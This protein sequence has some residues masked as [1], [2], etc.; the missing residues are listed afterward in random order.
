[1][2]GFAGI[3]KS[4][5]AAVTSQEI[6]SMLSLIKYRG[7]DDSGML[8]DGPIGLGSVRLSI[9][10]LSSGRMPIKTE[11]E[12]LWIVYN[13][14]TY[15]YQKYK[16]DLL[17]KGH[18]FSTRSDTEVI[19][20]LYQEYGPSCFKLLNGMFGIC[21]WDKEKNQLVL[22]R[23]QLGQKPVYYA[24]TKKGFI[25]GSE[26][27]TILKQAS[28]LRVVSQ[29]GVMS[30]MTLGY[31]LGKLTMFE[32]IYQLEPGEYLTYDLQNES[33]KTEKFWNLEYN[34]DP[35]MTYEEAKS[36]VRQRMIQSVE[37]RMI[38][39]VPV[40]I[41]LSGG[42]DST[43]VGGIVSKILGLKLKSFALGYTA[44]SGGAAIRFNNDV[45]HADIAAK[46][47]GFD[48]HEH[49][50]TLQGQLP[51]ILEKIVW[52]YDEPCY[53]P[54]L[55]PL[56]LLSNL[57]A[58]DFKVSLTGDGGD[59]LFCGYEMYNLEKNFSGF[60][61]I[62]RAIR[63]P[64][65]GFVEGM[66]LFREGI[67]NQLYRLSTNNSLDRY[68]TWKEIFRRKKLPDYIKNFQQDDQQNFLQYMKKSSLYEEN[69]RDYTPHLAYNDIVFWISSHATRCFDRMSMAS[70]LEC[71]SSFLDHELVQFSQQIPYEYK[72]KNQ[73][74][75]SILK[76]AFSDLIPSEI[77]NRQKGSMLSPSSSW[78]RNHLNDLFNEL[79]SREAIERAGVLHYESTR[80]IFD[81]HVSKKRYAMI[82]VWTLASL[83]LWHE[84]HIQERRQPIATSFGT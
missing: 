8:L 71:R 84:I 63:A 52:H 26:I 66:G 23:D 13:G 4:Q 19:L 48:H 80:Q 45:L 44:E 79:F 39:D 11:D 10:G 72:L 17:K 21:I 75:K 31:C 55:V 2:C 42:I 5:N 1:M 54:T 67:Q 74:T 73:V 56:F 14:E 27:K 18:S 16:D 35:A 53:A 64:A 32:G 33:I 40:S 29:A 37:S 43:V 3:I 81:D 7:P 77:V 82:P 6:Q 47:F 36:A 34:P 12:K 69:G 50:V 59:E 60:N 28:E 68:L 78:I 83:Q 30:Y 20:H 9:I 58:K 76:D 61:R 41:F 15:N 51:Q 49:K 25:F 62:P 70:S 24:K 22:A 38:S 46:R 65:F 57:V